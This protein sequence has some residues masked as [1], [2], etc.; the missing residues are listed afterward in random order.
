MLPDQELQ[1]NWGRPYALVLASVTLGRAELGARGNNIFW[2]LCAFK[3]KVGPEL[4]EGSNCSVRTKLTASP[5]F[6]ACGSAQGKDISQ[7]A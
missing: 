5:L 4:P 7:R 3:A 6:W 1:K 2:G